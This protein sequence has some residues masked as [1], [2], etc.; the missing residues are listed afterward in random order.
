[1]G[2]KDADKA[3]SKLEM[4]C[5][6]E[7]CD[8]IGDDSWYPF[9]ETNPVTL[10]IRAYPLCSNK[11]YLVRV[12]ARPTDQWHSVTYAELKYETDSPLS[13]KRVFDLWKKY[14]YDKVPVNEEILSVEWFLEHGFLLD[15]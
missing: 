1:M 10:T 7:S 9:D 6:N 3:K 5:L 8:F 13:A 11:R 4:D 12:T 14:I 15:T 2:R